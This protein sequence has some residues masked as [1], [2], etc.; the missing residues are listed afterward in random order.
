MNQPSAKLGTSSP[1]ASAPLHVAGVV[2]QVLEERSSGD[3]TFSDGPP[4]LH[5]ERAGTASSAQ[6]TSRRRGQSTD[7]DW[8]DHLERS[9]AH[10]TPLGHLFIENLRTIAKPMAQS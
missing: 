8:A 7:A 3:W 9:N 6:G 5:A 1:A 2:L 4:E 10:I